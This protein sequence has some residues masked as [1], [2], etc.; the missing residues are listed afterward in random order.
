[1]AHTPQPRHEVRPFTIDVPDAHID[2]LRGPLGTQRMAGRA[3]RLWLGPWRTAQ[4]SAGARRVLAQVLGLTQA[5]S[6]SERAPQFT[7]TIDGANVHIVHGA[8]QRFDDH[9]ATLRVQPE[10]VGRI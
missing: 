4:L 3:A 2:D 5:R 6:T 8:A 9:G 7:T 1:M 10:T